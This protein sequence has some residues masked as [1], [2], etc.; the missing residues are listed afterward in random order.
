VLRDTRGGLSTYNITFLVLCIIE[1]EEVSEQA[2]EYIP[3]K[4]VQIEE[5]VHVSDFQKPEPFIQLFNSY[6]IIF[7]RWN[8]R[9]RMLPRENKFQVT[10]G[11]SLA[12]SE[13]EFDNPALHLEY[14]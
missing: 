1:E 6:G 12:E 11:R 9:M 13:D 4:E 5:E 10:P 7:I 14:E 2:F 8:V 3:V